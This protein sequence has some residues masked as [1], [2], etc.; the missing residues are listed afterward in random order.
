MYYPGFIRIVF[1][2]FFRGGA[3]KKIQNQDKRSSLDLHV[4][5]NIV[6]FLSLLVSGFWI[7]SLSSGQWMVCERLGVHQILSGMHIVTISDIILLRQCLP[8]SLGCHLH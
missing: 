1:T 4:Q 5:L 3:A 7:L 2:H 6:T 8:F